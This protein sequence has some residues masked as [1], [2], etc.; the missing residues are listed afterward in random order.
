MMELLGRM[1]KDF[2]L[3][4]MRSRRFFKKSGCL[5]KIN[6]LHYWPLKKVLTDKYK[7]AD[8]E[9]AA[10]AD[11]L[12]PMLRWDPNKR[13]SAEQ[14]LKHPWLT[15][16]ANYDTKVNEVSEESAFQYE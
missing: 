5:R 13:A 1:P 11:F 16:E 15:M 3:S 4:G 2:A 14:M 12:L 7:F 9:A 8:K 10:F 6:G